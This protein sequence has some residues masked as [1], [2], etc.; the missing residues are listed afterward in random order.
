MRLSVFLRN[1]TWFSIRDALTSQRDI[2]INLKDGMTFCVEFIR[3]NFRDDG[4]G[5]TLKAIGAHFRAWHPRNVNWLKNSHLRFERILIG[6]APGP[7]PISK[8]KVVMYMEL[9]GETLA[10]GISSKDPG[11]GKRVIV[12]QFQLPMEDIEDW[13]TLSFSP[14]PDGLDVPP[15]IEK[16]VALPRPD[17]LEYTSLQMIFSVWGRGS[18]YT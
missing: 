16:L 18:I 12:V 1:P 15:L 10:A 6:N 5:L 7:T 9:I 8:P 2:Q 14:D 4:T 17:V 3:D 11:V 13:F